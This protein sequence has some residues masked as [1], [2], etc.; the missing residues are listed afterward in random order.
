MGGYAVHV[1]GVSELVRYHQAIFLTPLEKVEALSPE[2]TQLVTDK[3][4]EY[5]QTRLYLETLLRRMPP[6]DHKIHLGHRGALDVMP[7][8]L[9]PAKQGLEAL[10]PRILIADGTGLGKTVELGILLSELVRRGRGRRILVVAIRSMLAQLQREL[11]ARFTLPLVRLD[12]EGLL[13]VQNKIP[14]NRNPFGFFDRCIISVDTLKN[15]ALYRAWLE[16]IRWDVIVVD[17]CHN[18]AG[19]TSQ[20]AELARLLSTQCDALV[21]TSATPHNGRPESFA[22]LMNMLDPTSIADP[23]SFTKEDVKHLFVRRFKK[24][25]EGEARAEL[26]DRE[27]KT[28]EAEGSPAEE[29]AFGAVHALRLHGLGRKRSGEDALLRWTLVKALGSS[30]AACAESIE[31][32]IRT[33]EQALTAG[34]EPHPFAAELEKDL[35]GLRSALELVQKAGEPGAFIKLERL[36]EELRSVGFDGSAKSPRVVIFSERIR[37]LTLLQ[38]A[39]TERFRLP[40]KALAVFTAGTGDDEQQREII[41]S[42]G[43]KE[44]PLRLLLCSDAASEGINLH[45]QCHHLFHF[46]VPWSLIRLT[47]RNGRIDRYGQHHRPRLFYLTTRTQQSTADQRVVARLIEKEREVERQLG[48]AGALL[49]LYV[50]EDEDDALT[51]GV[52]R[53]LSAEALIP[54]EPARPAAAQNALSDERGTATPVSGEP[55]QSTEGPVDLLALLAEVEVEQA[56]TPTL[57]AL[58]AKSPSLFASD[59]DFVTAALRHLERSPVVGAEPLDWKASADERTVELVAPEPFKC[60]VEPFLPREAIPGPNAPY[61]LVEGRAMVQEKLRAALDDEGRWPDWHLLWEQHPLVEWVLDALASAYARLEAPL[62]RVPGLGASAVF[63][64]QGLLYNHESE[65]VTAEWL[66]LELAGGKFAD[67]HLDLEAVRQRVGLD[68]TLVNPGTGSSKHAELQERVPEAIQLARARLLALRQER[69]SGDVSSRARKETRRLERWQ[70][71]SLARIERKRTA[72]ASR[73]A[74]VPRHVERRL[75]DEIEAVKRIRENHDQLLKSLSVN[76]ESDP[77][78]RLVAVFTGA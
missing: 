70:S 13:R 9:V 39:L 58:T 19:T 31:A 41:E 49:G 50:A 22:N 10:R 44:S 72:W 54:D 74:T 29:A 30:P 24:D 65:A 66:G 76:P 69:V 12:S 52:A 27:V 36:A 47:Q 3:T 64:L 7:Y 60:H 18:V 59:W 51:R 20:R 23:T 21:M 68:R 11:W 32:R 6:T 78:V 48:D 40:E 62:L 56:K 37:T 2:N 53:G 63:L 15:D 26:Q 33:T 17:E 61:R 57:D 35:S 4:P 1:Q 14:A 5:R 55:A 42:F 28:V 46:D 16:Q 67:G 75:A 25:V 71:E 73:G 38:E 8:Q 34:D 77:F 45:H 43:R